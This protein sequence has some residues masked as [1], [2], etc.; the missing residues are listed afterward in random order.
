MAAASSSKM[1]ILRAPYFPYVQPRIRSAS[2][3]EDPSRSFQ[4][5]IPRSRDVQVLKRPPRPEESTFF[6]ARPTLNSVWD[7]FDKN[8]I[9]AQQALRQSHIWPLPP[10][11]QLPQPNS[12]RWKTA[13]EMRPILGDVRV[14]MTMHSKTVN[15]LNEVN[16]LRYLCDL[17]G[18]PE[19]S[20]RLADT[21][22][23]WQKSLLVEEAERERKEDVVDELGRARGVGRK[24]TASAQ[25]WIIPSKKAENHLDKPLLAPILPG[26]D[27]LASGTLINTPAD[28]PVGEFL[29]N[30]LPLPRHFN[31]VYDREIVL[32][33]LRITGLLGAYNVFALVRGGGYSSQAYSV[34]LGLARALRVMRNDVEDILRAGEL[35]CWL[36]S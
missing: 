2:T 6:T 16:R 35:S 29:V 10:S 21:M 4:P 14:T 17:A 22:T 9:S 27:L 32:R 5:Y 12:I 25:V 24:K 3:Y 33:P 34:A 7:G 36:Q 28:L 11:L 19:L 26:E 8:I 1:R 30:Q 23:K 13:E 20:A 18:K 31:R 15:K